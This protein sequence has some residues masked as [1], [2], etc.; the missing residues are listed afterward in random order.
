M[1]RM[2]ADCVVGMDDGGS[3]VRGMIGIGTSGLLVLT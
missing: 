2:T 1:R 3:A